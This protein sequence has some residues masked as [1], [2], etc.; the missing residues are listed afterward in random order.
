MGNLFSI[1]VVLFMA[2]FTTL[3][4]IGQLA[5]LIGHAIHRTSYSMSMTL[6]V[7]CSIMWTIFY[8]ITHLA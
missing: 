5:V 1:S 4:F 8:A 7:T 3:L 2:I 6:I